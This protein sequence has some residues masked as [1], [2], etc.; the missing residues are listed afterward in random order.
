MLASARFPTDPGDRRRYA[1]ADLSGDLYLIRG[2]RSRPRH[3]LS[4]RRVASSRRQL[5]LSTNGIMAAGSV[6]PPTGKPAPGIANITV[7]AAVLLVSSLHISSHVC[8]CCRLDRG[9]SR[10]LPV[11]RIHSLR[12]RMAHPARPG[13][14]SRFFRAVRTGRLLAAVAV[15]SLDG[16]HV[17]FDGDGGRCCQCDS[18]NLRDLD[19]AP[20]GTCTGASIDGLGRR[21]PDRIVV[22]GSVWNPLVR[23]DGLLF[24][25]DRVRVGA[26]NRVQRRAGSALPSDRRRMF[27]GSFRSQQAKRGRRPRAGTSGHR[28]SDG[29]A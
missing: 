29:R 2:L 12:R 3:S 5:L 18:C 19:P 17:L 21:I 15:L 10:H 28:G 9:S 11:R 20:I 1:T 16:R 8:H 22:W 25:S 27:L 13:H 6:H 24:Q 7:V 14:V 23:A 4:A 26:G